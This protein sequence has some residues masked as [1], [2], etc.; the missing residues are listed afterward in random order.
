VT[1]GVRVAHNEQTFS[2]ITSGALTGLGNV[3]GKSSE[4]VF[5]YAISPR[6]H[7]SP[8]AMLYAR[9]ASGYQPG[10][11]NIALPDVPPSVDASTLT[12][13]EVG[14]KTMFDEHRWM[15]DVSV[16]DIEWDKIQ[17][18]A[19]NGVVAYLANGG[20]ARS[21][22]LE[23]STLYAPTA[24]LRLGFNGAYTDAYLTEAVPSIGGANGDKLAAI[25]TWALSAT[26]DYS[27][28]VHAD[29]NGR[30]GGGIRYVGD[31]FSG[32]ESAPTTF[33]QDSYTVVDLNA[34]VSNDRWTIRFFIKNL[35]NQKVYTNLAAL[36][37]AA[38]GQIAQ[39]R[40]VPLQPRM[41]GI[42]FDAKF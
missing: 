28:P 10:G 19:N 5:T 7:I 9:I 32:V 29:W 42:G 13:Y 24:A 39:V 25:P 36:S 40:G 20:T 26:A 30:V 33:P 38:T 15:F 41:I 3:S 11:P 34:D 35:T 8:D 6:L 2:E 27:F 21:R 31:T 23:F 1:A 18:S 22:G 14:L 16:F 37:S 12:N 17:V 4:D